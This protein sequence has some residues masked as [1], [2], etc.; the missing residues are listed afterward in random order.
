MIDKTPPNRRPKETTKKNKGFE[1]TLK[2]LKMDLQNV[3][4]IVKDNQ[5]NRN[6]PLDLENNYNVCFFS[7][8]VRALFS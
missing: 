5:R 1:G 8:V 7:F 6:I 2:T 3:Q 4:L